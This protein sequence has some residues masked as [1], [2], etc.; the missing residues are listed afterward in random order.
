M[1][2]YKNRN[3]SPS[4]RQGDRCLHEAEELVLS[5]YLWLCRHGARCGSGCL[6]ECAGS[7]GGAMT[8]A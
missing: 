6:L 4:T 5:T 3:G 8:V 2:A 7:R 1:K